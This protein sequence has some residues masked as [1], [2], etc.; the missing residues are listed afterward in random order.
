MTKCGSSCKNGNITDEELETATSSLP[1]SFSVFVNIFI[2]RT[3][4]IAPVD[5]IATRPKLSFSEALLSFFKLATPSP[6]AKINGTVNAPVVAPDASK[7]MARN[8]DD[9]NIA[10]AKMN[11]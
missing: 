5:A 10:S 6:K 1:D 11:P 4:K 3:D 8:S 2:M 7:A 9:E